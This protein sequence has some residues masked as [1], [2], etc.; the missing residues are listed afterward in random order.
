MA[1]SGGTPGDAVKPFG[2]ALVAAAKTAGDEP[3]GDPL[4]VTAFQLGWLMGDIVRG[5]APTPVFGDLKDPEKA[6]QGA[7]AIS[8]AAFLTTLKVTTDPGPDAVVTALHGP[9]PGATPP[10]PPPPDPKTEAQGWE[11]TLAGA[12]LGADPRYAKAY[13]V[14]RNLNWLAA[15]T[16][17]P[18]VFQDTQVLAVLTYLD[19]LSTALPPHAARSVAN[20]IRR[21]QQNGAGAD[22]AQLTAQ[23]RL[24][25]TIIAGDKKATEV[26]EPQNYLDA[27][28]QLSVR[29]HAIA[30]SVLREYWFLV[31]VVLLLFVGGVLLVALP[32]QGGSTVAG[33]STVIA[34]FGLTWKGIGGTVGKLAGKLEAPLWG[35][36]VDDAVTDAITLVASAST[37]PPARDATD[38]DYLGRA[39]LRGQL[40]AASRTDPSTA[41]ES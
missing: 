2:D 25:R 15:Q 41:P 18:D 8:L 5:Q 12:L 32:D 6:G 28:K 17:S 24:W 4:V 27:A 37:Q 20:S 30:W 14:G 36:E 39:A 31:V 33:L 7:Q 13:A 34:A 29:L 40:V 21:W 22:Q 3:A 35:A 19:D 11:A 9:D 38:H 10:P 26:L 1:D 16:P 23:C